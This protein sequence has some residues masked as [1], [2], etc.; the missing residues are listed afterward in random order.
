MLRRKW[1]NA[2]HI[3]FFLDFFFYLVLQVGILEDD[4]T[5]M[6]VVCAI[7][8]FPIGILCC[9]AMRQ[10]RCANCGAVFG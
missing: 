3:N 6:G 5:C 9:M 10:R 8:F 7:V 1:I 2:V 4:F